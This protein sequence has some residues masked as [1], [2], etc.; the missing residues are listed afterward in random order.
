MIEVG[1]GDL[2]EDGEL[3]ADD[4]EDFVD[5][6][7]EACSPINVSCELVEELD[8]CVARARPVLEKVRKG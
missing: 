7:S 3:D 6:E 5:A 8:D 1:L 2:G 4:E